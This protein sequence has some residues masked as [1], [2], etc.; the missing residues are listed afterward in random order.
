MF[1]Y[2]SAVSPQFKPLTSPRIGHWKKLAKR[3]KKT[4]ENLSHAEALERVARDNG[5]PSW[6]KVMS[7]STEEGIYEDLYRNSVAVIFDIKDYQEFASATESET[8]WQTD[9]G[10]LNYV[11]EKLYQYY[12]D[13]PEHDPERDPDGPWPEMSKGDYF[14]SYV[15]IPV[16]PAQ[17]P[18]NEREVFRF[19]KL[20]NERSFFAPNYVVI[21]GKIYSVFGDDNDK[22][23]SKIKDTLG[24]L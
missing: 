8:W 2:D 3:L 17:R 19:L 4:N 21:Y 6:E 10:Y 22:V 16:V 7:L 13:H 23:L 9:V 12:V 18:Q 24:F 20:I 1:D 14:E 11:S 5:F 15:D